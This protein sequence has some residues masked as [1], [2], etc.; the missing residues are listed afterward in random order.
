LKNQSKEIAELQSKVNAQDGIIKSL[1]GDAEKIKIKWE[2]FIKDE[3]KLAYNSGAKLSNLH[4]AI[5]ACLQ[6]QK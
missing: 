2:I 3:Q 5:F 1:E 4:E 6:D